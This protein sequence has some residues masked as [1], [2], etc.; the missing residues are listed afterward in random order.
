MT[1]TILKTMRTILMTKIEKIWTD[2][3]SDSS[4]Q[5]GLLLKRLSSKVK[6]DIYVALKALGRHRCI[7]VKKRIITQH[8]EVANIKIRQIT[9]ETYTEGNNPDRNFLLILLLN[10]EHKDIFS[11]L[12]EDLI[13]AV[14]ETIDENELIG[15]LLSRLEKWQMLFDRLSQQGLSKSAQVGLYGELYFLQNILMHTKQAEYCIK[16][17]VGPEMAVQD[18][19][20]AEQAVEVKTTH[21]KNHQKIHIASERQLDT[22]IIPYIYLYHIS[23]DIRSNV[24]DTLNQITD[25]LKDRLAT[26]PFASNAFCLKLLEAGYFDIHA[27]FYEEFGYSIRQLNVYKIT[28]DFPKITESSVPYG[29]GD[30]HYTIIARNEKRWSISEKELFYKLTKS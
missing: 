4:F 18:F 21:G 8:E 12:C 22:A 24:G 9:I 1:T 17:W 13:H 2:L 27:H 20:F 25:R 10:N 3:E 15:Q 6:P 19:Q 5:H 29:V 23:L 26:N 7:A 16:A 11:T 28:D 30:V 14:E